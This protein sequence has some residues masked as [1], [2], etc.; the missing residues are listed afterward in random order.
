MSSYEIELHEFHNGQQEIANNR[1]KRT[2]M[3]CGRRFG[4]TTMFE[5]LAC[6]FAI[7]GKQVGWFSPKYKHMQGSFRRIK[8]ALKPVI[9]RSSSTEGLIELV[10]GGF[11]RFWTLQDKDAGRGDF[12]HEVLI[13]EA[14]LVEIGLRDIWEQAIAPTLLD[15][16]GNAWM[17]GT[18]KGI[19]PENFFYFACTNTDDKEGQVWKEFH[20]P[21]SANPNINAKALADFKEQLPPLVYQQEVLAEF[22]D[23]SGV[24]FFALDDL[25]INGQPT[26]YPE[27]CDSV[28]AVIDTAVKDGK[29]HDSTAVSY[30]AY[31]DYKNKIDL[32]LLDWQALQIEGALLDTWLPAVEQRLKELKTECK[33]INLLP[34]YIEDKA[35]GSILLQQAKRRN[36]NVKSIDSKFSAMSKSE[37]AIAASGAV[38]Q[39]RVKISQ[40]A[41]DKQINLKGV[42]KNHWLSQVTQFRIGNDHGN[43]ADDLL[44]TFTYA[45]L[46]LNR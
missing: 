42:R 4:K 8:K 46:Q 18:P 21:T 17:A 39:G 2:V 33:A 40:Y 1:A 28:F 10:T 3:R 5:D 29:Q 27:S 43:Q 26:K 7:N 22:V 9:T 32:V 14:S 11:I 16:D 13:D 31:R 45:V 44:D 36:V 37:R 12:Y 19:D 24:A 41:Y 30:Y 6:L 23:W 15:Y 20:A 25:L 35:S 38:Y 34:I